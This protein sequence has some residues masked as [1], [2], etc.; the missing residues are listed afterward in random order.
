MILLIHI[1]I[2]DINKL[3]F[4]KD[5]LKEASANFPALEVIDFDN[6]SD[7]FMID[8]CLKLSEESERIAVIIDAESAEVG[9]GGIVKFLNALLRKKKQQVLIILN[10]EHEVVFKMVRIFK[11]HHTNL[12]LNAQMGKLITFF[13]A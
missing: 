13:K 3:H 12:N 1:E 6:H 5:I 8:S 11:D 2:N 10:G 4:E 7:A 9:T